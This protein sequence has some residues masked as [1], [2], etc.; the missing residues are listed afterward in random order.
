MTYI[1][2][3][4]THNCGE[5]VA[6]N[7]NGFA[8]TEATLDACSVYQAEGIRSFNVPKSTALAWR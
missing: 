7:L 2:C 6:L 1:N 5:R 3:P 4:A 8:S